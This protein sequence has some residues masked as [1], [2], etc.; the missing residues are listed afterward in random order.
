M[1]GITNNEVKFLVTLDIDEDKSKK[2]IDNFLNKTIKDQKLTFAV[3][4][5]QS[6]KNIKEF[7]DKHQGKTLKLDFDINKGD[8]Q[9]TIKTFLDSYKEAK[10]SLVFDVDTKKTRVAINNAIKTIDGLNPVKIALDVDRAKSKENISEYIRNAKFARKDIV[11]GVDKS[12]KTI[13]NN[14]LKDLTVAKVGVALKIAKGGIS[15]LK[16]A[17]N[18]TSLTVDKLVLGLD[19]V[20][21]KKR[22]A[23]QINKM[24]LPKFKVD[25]V[26][27]VKPIVSSNTAQNVSKPSPKTENSPSQNAYLGTKASV[28]KQIKEEYK[29]AGKVVE[30]FNSTVAK[31]EQDF[32]NRLKRQGNQLDIVRDAHTKE[33]TKITATYRNSA[34]EIQKTFYTPLVAKYDTLNS[35][36]R[37]GAKEIRGFVAQIEKIS[38]TETFDLSKGIQKFNFRLMEA[39]HNSN[40]LAKEYGRFADLS[41]KA[42]SKNE[43]DK[44][45]NELDSHIA[46][47]RKRNQLEKSQIN[48]M[49]QREQLIA[50]L[51]RVEKLYLR[52]VNK[53]QAENIKQL[54]QSNSLMK[55]IKA[56]PTELYKLNMGDITKAQN[57][58]TKIRSQ[59]KQLNADATE[60]TKNSMGIISALKVAMEK[61][62]IWMLAST[63]FYGTI[64]TLREF[65]TIIVD[66]D[67]K[68][69]ELKKV[70]ADGT[71]FGKIFADATVQAERFGQ[72]ISSTLDAYSMFAKQGFKGE[73]L[74]ELASAGLV[75]GNVG[76]IATGRASEYLTAS[77][78]Q[79]N[80][81]TSEA[82]SIVDSWNEISN[83]YATTV[84]N[85]A[86]GQAKAGAT[87]KALGMD[88]DELNAVVGVLNARTKQSGN[89]IGNFIK[90]TF[91]N[92]ISD[93]GM[94]ILSSLGVRL[95]DD[96]GN[97]RNIMDIYKDVAKEY[98]KLSQAERNQVTLGLGGKYHI[99][100]L[101]TLLD[102]LSK[103]DSMYDQMLNSSRDSANSAIEENEKYMQSLQAKINLARVE[104]EK[105]A[106]TIG[107]AVMTDAMVAGLK[108]FGTILSGITGFVE[109]FGVLPITILGIVTALT[110]FSNRFG[111]MINRITV[112]ENTIGKFLHSLKGLGRD[113]N[114]TTTN[115][116]NNTEATKSNT[117]ETDKNSESKKKAAK[118]AKLLSLGFGAVG[119]ASMAVAWG[120]EALV[121]WYGKAQRAKEELQAQNER[122]LKSY[123][124]NRDAINGLLEEYKKLSEMDVSSKLDGEG[125]Q[126]LLDVQNELG[127]LM[128]ELVRGEDQYGN[129]VFYS[130]QQAQIKV[131]TL[132]REL[133]VQKQLNEE[134]LKEEQK[135]KL[136]TARKTIKKESSNQE[137]QLA[138][139]FAFASKMN[140]LVYEYN[141]LNLLDGVSFDGDLTNGKS[142]NSIEDVAKAIQNV[143]TAL[144]Q[145]AEH[146]F[147]E[148]TVK[149][150]EQLK[151][152]LESTYLQLLQ[153]QKDV[154]SGLNIVKEDYVSTLEGVINSTGDFSEKAK[155]DFQDVANS[156]VNLAESET[157]LGD[158]SDAITLALAGENS[159]LETQFNN[160]SVAISNMKKSGVED[161]KELEENFGESFKS[162]R[163]TIMEKSGLKEGTVAY[164]RL[165][166]A[167]KNYIHN[168]MEF[169][170]AVVEIMER[171]GKS[172]EEAITTLEALGDG[173]D[174]LGEFGNEIKEFV[175]KLQKLE[176]VSDNLIGVTMGQVE[177]VE[178]LLY[179]YN[180]LSTKTELSKREQSVL[181]DTIKKLTALYPHLTKEGEIRT[182]NIEIENK[183]VKALHEAYELAQDGVLTAEENMTLYTAQET[184]NRI[185]NIGTEI[186][187]L[188]KLQ[189]QYEKLSNSK[190]PVY[191]EDLLPE[192][193]SFWMPY[194][195]QIESKQKELNELLGK[196]VTSTGK[197]ND[198][199]AEASKRSKENE[200]ARKNEAKETSELEKITK[201][202]ALTFEKL[203][204]AQREVQARLKKYPTYS[205]QYR[206][207]L[208]D[209]NRLIQKQIELN[210]QKS[211]ELSNISPTS[212]AS[213]SGGTVTPS[214]WSG[215]I[216]S[217]FGAV[218]KVRNNKPHEGIDIAGKTGTSIGANIGGKVSSTGYNSRSGNYVYVEDAQGLKHLYAHLSKISVAVGQ[219]VDVGQ[220]L[221]KMGSTGNSTGSHLH[222]GIYQNGKAIDPSSYVSQARNG[223]Y[224]SGSSA[225]GSS[226]QATVW[227]FFKAKGLNDQAIAGIM[228]NIAQESNFNSKSVNKSSGASGIFQWLGSR[229]TELQSYAKSLGKSWDDIQVQLEFAWKELNSTEKK[230]LTSLQRSD[231]SASQHASEFDRLF[232]RSGRSQVAKR[233]SFANQYYSQYAGSGIQ[234]ISSNDDYANALSQM[235]S[236]KQENIALAEA[237]QENYY[238]GIKSRLDEFQRNR[239]IEDYGIARQEERQKNM[240]EYNKEYE[241]SVNLQYNAEQRK[242]K[243]YQAEY[244][245][246]Q[247]IQRAGG[248]TLSQQDELIDRQYELQ[249]VMLESQNQVKAYYN[250]V[251]SS[252]LSGFDNKMAN[253]IKT[254]EWEDV[255]I[256]AIDRTN[257]RYNK[258]LEKVAKT[259]ESQL[260]TAR[261]ELEYVNKMLGKG[262]LTIEMYQELT[263]R[264]F[265]L[266]NELVELNEALHNVNYEMVQTVAIVSDLQIDD[267]EF[268]ISYSQALRNLYEEGS[269]D[270]KAGLDFE[271]TKLQE[272]LAL[273]EKKGKDIQEAMK[274]KD[275]GHAQLQELEEQLE[276]NALAYL[277]VKNAIKETEEAIKNFGKA[278][279]EQIKD[280]RDELADE[281]ISALK[282]AISEAKDIELARID[283]LIKAEE[284]R[285][286]K[287]MKQYDDEL[288]AYT[289]IIDQKRREIKDED[290]DRS[291]TNKL[292]E[293]NERKQEIQNRINLLSNVTDYAGIKEREGLQKEL[294]KIEKEIDEE[295]YQYEKDI[296]EQQL[297]DLLE[298]KTEHIEDLKEKDDK[299]SS[300]ILK[301]LNKQRTYWEK[302]YSDLLNDEA[303][304]AKM[305][306][307]ILAGN[308]EEVEKEFAKHIKNLTDS[309][310]AL[311]DKF[312]GTWKAVGTQ[313]RE[314]VIGSMQDLLLKIK[315]VENE[316]T[317]L[318]NMKDKVTGDFGGIPD[319][320]QTVENNNKGNQNKM[321]EADMKVI[322]AKFMNEQIA[323]SLDPVKDKSRIKNIKDKSYILAKEGREEG[324]TI[325]ESQSLSSILDKLSSTQLSQLGGYFQSN[326]NSSSFVTQEY[327][328]Y[329]ENFGKDLQKGTVLSTGDKQ[330]L[331]AKYMREQL[332]PATQDTKEREALRATSDQLA[333]QGRASASLISPTVGYEQSFKRLTEKQ[334]A[335]LGKFM[336]DNQ[337]VV[338]PARLRNILYRYADNLMRNQSNGYVGLGVG[339]MT[340]NYGSTGGVDGKGGKVAL[341]HPNEI[342][343][344]PLD[345][346]RLLRVSSIMDNIMRT[347]S[348]V[349]STP[350]LSK[351]SSTQNNTNN[352][353]STPLHI[354][355]DK[356]YGTKSNID[357]LTKQINNKL[358]R[359]KGKR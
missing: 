193:H 175:E 342:V 90:S 23:E 266:K 246:I 328:D 180:T 139:A 70:M 270:Y 267:I 184:Y 63:A 4:V 213:V 322:L 50:N 339:G 83:N 7:L 207:A 68:M 309:L 81:Q 154:M 334:Q 237:L 218:D 60:A 149:N 122:E 338:A 245:Y 247:K 320:N 307:D 252:R 215:S 96:Y 19:I 91:P 15:E 80:K 317:K 182:D 187:A 214:G 157:E 61:F 21:T 330:V 258:T 183:A 133:E 302:Y 151:D 222:Y 111:D 55:P 232:E 167:L 119:I 329:I 255:K 64:R 192:P 202:Y 153:S 173:A 262:N 78:L 316:I 308:F 269:G 110:L 350:T 348:G 148:S 289:K 77:I 206:Q 198:V 286:D 121:G 56:N 195:I 86:Q 273:V 1:T 345:T 168:S 210:N 105:L 132:E 106:I 102:D 197:L 109:K 45:N 319:V 82:M 357:D 303:Y 354:N 84:E 194:D 208:E 164:E 67:T 190:E 3:N 257:I 169:D 241:D 196:L 9:K 113:I 76:D 211:K 5:G 150:L 353:N 288:K 272:K 280:K 275:L 104:L 89:E 128:P 226:A 62:P 142:L 79:W 171:T 108:L 163:E 117:T 253:Y 333:S 324:S 101:Q 73:E 32:I 51:T 53:E 235:E 239:D 28:I 140:K 209:E 336:L 59:I 94:S 259:R 16:D 285:H 185:V 34:N 205:K 100:R 66:I 355:I 300:D 250:E 299:Y 221:G 130:A 114:T 112:G 6:N 212:V 17:V 38:N 227:N 158:F 33:I 129:K 118:S 233:E 298:E 284:E 35:K 277:E 176:S 238:K 143:K 95:E 242:L 268:E 127:K 248:L 155:K 356:F 22:I 343:S 314:N 244:E 65:G 287:V 2:R 57:E 136:K 186:D 46:E 326:S 351:A 278:I 47:I 126:K 13:M 295:K 165:N 161:A 341:L 281:I 321:S 36:T 243:N 147:S 144:S 249:K 349:I 234:S 31:G 323:G 12:S 152:G 359:E 216:T 335:E 24:T 146:G 219:L 92:L 159:D 125:Y 254:L 93:K 305:R 134:K 293:L 26:A 188:Y 8:S 282:D 199:N 170:R 203:N 256:Q 264:A 98:V 310:P 97:L 260:K 217:K 347:I 291:H 231:L 44:L 301:T 49:N 172:R 30:T 145:K 75:A 162:I 131:D 137:A 179:V 230:S 283:E 85:L 177:A 318:N 69:T 42:T 220:E 297:D 225:T 274:N 315:E 29:Q 107:E 18:G 25:V 340:K 43:L 124:D 290:R 327:I 52:T 116:G 223:G 200:K 276:D 39:Q 88:F 346:E 306:E 40:I 296:R 48:L 304:F 265:D 332:I 20:A 181:S 87:A 189:E 27:N 58:I 10:G 352:D 160:L 103:V 236:I 204:T 331:L 174:A 166:T 313:I 14:Y 311:Q 156:V 54:L 71:D 123:K 178:D 337:N 41:M 228:G 325:N 115:I 312:D 120:I 191:V 358:L 251:I 271:L 279:E 229:K 201:K 135:E 344:N 37:E 292:S 263:Q 240:L 72:T 141:E 11:F 74:N 261:E 99:S 224:A 138:Q 294:A